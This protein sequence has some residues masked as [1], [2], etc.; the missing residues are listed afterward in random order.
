MSGSLAIISK[1]ERLDWDN[2]VNIGLWRP[3]R[4]TELKFSEGRMAIRGTKILWIFERALPW[5]L[6]KILK[7]SSFSEKVLAYQSYSFF[8]TSSFALR[9][10]PCHQQSYCRPSKKSNSLRARIVT[11]PPVSLHACCHRPWCRWRIVMGNHVSGVPQ[12]FM[13][14]QIK[15]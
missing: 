2:C 13:T 11:P 5:A 3:V 7:Q 8:E 12:A 14:C 1:R 4:S 15:A 6:A 10:P 9:S